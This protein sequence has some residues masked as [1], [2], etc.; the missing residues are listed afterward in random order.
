VT[1]ETL[2]HRR[3]IRLRDY[4]YAQAGAYFITVCTNDR[5]GLFGEIIDGITQLSDFGAAAQETW[6]AIPEHVPHV[7][8]DSFVVM[9]NHVHG[10]VIIPVGAQHAAPLQRTNAVPPGSLAAVI[11]SFKSAATK[12]IN[13]LRATPGAP[14]WQ[15][16]YHEHVIRNDRDLD[17]IR[18]YITENPAQW[19]EDGFNPAKHVGSR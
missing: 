10:I 19:A 12:G 7:D 13:E 8:L 9:P 2:H 16:N 4:D 1:Y 11:R 18:Q 17:R 15:R 5:Q 6:L 3:S 14:V